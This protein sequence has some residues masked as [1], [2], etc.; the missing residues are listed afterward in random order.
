M[1]NP[2]GKIYT[3]PFPYTDASHSKYRP[4][5]IVIEEEDDFEVLYITRKQTENA[6]PLHEKDFLEWGLEHI[7]YVS[8]RKSIPFDKSL[9]TEENYLWS[10]TQKKIADILEAIIEKYKWVLMSIKR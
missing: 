1:L 4:T 9:F 7:S 5:V 3:L 10:I 6:I 2:I 8:I